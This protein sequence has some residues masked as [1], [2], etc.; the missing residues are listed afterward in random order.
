M[1]D[2]GLRPPFR[3]P[4]ERWPHATDLCI[5]LVAFLLTLAIWSRRT[6]VEGLSL[7][8]LPGVGTWLC[9]FVGSFALLWRRSHAL[10][11]HGL[12]LALSLLIFFGPLSNGL[13]AM[14]FTL[15]SVGR[16]EPDARASL[17]GLA[18]GL[19][20]IAID[21][22]VLTSPGVD[23]VLAGVM[24]FL[25]W[26]TGRRLRFRG[27][28]LRLL[29]E[30]AQHLEREQSLEA[31]RAVAAERTRIA[32]EM[33][34]VVAHQ[35]SLMTVQAGAA[36]TITTSD[37][38]A[39]GDAM[40]AVETAGRHALSEMR[41]LLGVLRPA[42]SGDELAPQPGV[43]DLPAL[44]RQVSDVGPKVTFEQRGDWSDVPASV[45]L[46]VYRIVQ[47][48]LTNV[49]KHAGDKVD[50]DVT[51]ESSGDG[52][53]VHTQDNGRGA[54]TGAPGGHGLVGMRERVALLGGTFEA[55]NRRE[56]GFD[57][58]VFLPRGAGVANEGAD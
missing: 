57:V 5:A 48:T 11:V 54:V 38:E 39:A 30:R 51:V 28:Y 29:E 19:I 10:K 52:V 13:V 32:R 9:A 34:D 6:D 14:A 15:Y 50:V 31:E 42:D 35:V 18:A 37:P 12:V 27:E 41:Q 26:Y 58:R 45:Q 55:A 49:I 2:V 21:S 24:A 53:F 25:L 8:T 33:H 3:G 56:R 44:A 23:D 7:N 4:F 47:E 17:L 43:S 36:R 22:R 40:A 46:A 16:Y 1:V 20:Y